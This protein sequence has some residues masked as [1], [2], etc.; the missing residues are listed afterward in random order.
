MGMYVD[1]WDFIE[2][3]KEISGL[4]DTYGTNIYYY[5]NNALQNSDDVSK[6]VY[7]N[8]DGKQVDTRPKSQAYV[9][10][11]YYT[12]RGA[13]GSSCFMRYS[14]PFEEL[15]V[16]EIT[17]QGEIQVSKDIKEHLEI[18]RLKMIIAMYLN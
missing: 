18:H 4:K 16:D 13:S 1:V 9:M 15:S 3:K 8:V 10:T 11:V 14:L 6:V 7:E 17:M 2:E 5:D 12:E